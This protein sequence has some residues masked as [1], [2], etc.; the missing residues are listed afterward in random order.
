M[1]YLK[2]RV[3]SFKYLVGDETNCACLLKQL[4]DSQPP[5]QT[6]TE[7]PPT[8]RTNSKFDFNSSVYSVV[9]QEDNGMILT[10]CVWGERKGEQLLF[11]NAAEVIELVRRKRNR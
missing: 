1:S 6:H 11:E 5:S 4:S 2:I 8:I 9:R 3:H 10:V 7:A